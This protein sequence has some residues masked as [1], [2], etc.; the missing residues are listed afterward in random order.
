MP[1]P[2]RGFLCF[3]SLVLHGVPE[4]EFGSPYDS[5]PAVHFQ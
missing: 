3:E 1:D 4:G 5:Y 2:N